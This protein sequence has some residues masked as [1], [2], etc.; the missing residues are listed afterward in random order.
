MTRRYMSRDLLTF[1]LGDGTS[2]AAEGSRPV[3][4]SNTAARL[5]RHCVVFKTL[6]Q[7]AADLC[8]A[9][10][11]EDKAAV[12]A[13]LR[14][15]IRKDLLQDDVALAAQLRQ[16]KPQRKPARISWLGMPTRNRLDSLCANLESY[17]DNVLEHGRE[18]SF[19]VVDDS[20]ARDTRALC[21]QRLR[22]LKRRRGIALHYA[23]AEEKRRFAALL[24][25]A[26]FDR[27]DI[28]FCLFGEEGC[29]STIG[30]NRNALLL[31]TAGEALF[32]PDDDTACHLGI[33]SG[34]EP[35]LALSSARDPN[36]SWLLSE[37]PDPSGPRRVQEDVLGL[38]ELLLGR[39]LPGCLAALPGQ[40]LSLGTCLPPFI[41]ELVNGREEVLFTTM[42]TEGIGIDDPLYYLRKRGPGRARLFESESTYQQ[43]LRTRR[44][45]ESARQL[46]L[47]EAELWNGCVVAYDNREL[48]PPFFP[49]LRGE[50]G[51][52]GLSAL[53]C[54]PSLCTGH[55]P[56]T[57]LHAA[58]ESR[59]FTKGTPAQAGAFLPAQTLIRLCL[60][61][62]KPGVEERTRVERM[63]GLGRHL[64]GLGA[65][66]P[67]EFERW[68]D[69][70]FLEHRSRELFS[71]EYALAE[72]GR[73]PAFWVRDC[74]RAK[75]ALRQSLQDR[76]RLIP[77]DLRPGRSLEEARALLQRLLL[78][79]GRLLQ[80][81]PDMVTAAREARARGQLIAPALSR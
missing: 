11:R 73:A 28:A 72:H 66:A 41:Q 63:R 18:I 52:F 77:H 21:R 2:L 29:G 20:Q 15:L 45:V 49:V 6:E 64:M 69:P 34:A 42:G 9:Y 23:G 5:L 24:R 19:V 51:I 37:H 54:V 25:T 43:L 38:H 59:S 71:L 46:T 57:V 48:L 4:V 68:L 3:R 55:I 62:Y 10:P 22:E 17:V 40:Q 32:A 8:R 58:G 39:D 61:A 44:V 78:R 16:R 74:E 35:G 1:P 60:N 70:L 30:A 56:R 65:L 76:T 31:Q 79:F 67:P 80:V 12:M 75:K 13:E 26:G 36:E 7:H 50:D 47:T 27:S 81:W 14:A 33:P 53:L